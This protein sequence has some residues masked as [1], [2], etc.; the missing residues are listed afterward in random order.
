MSKAT[1]AA[2]I[3]ILILIVDQVIK[4]IVKTNMYL[5]ESIPVF[6]DWFKIR[7]IENPGMAFGIDIPGKFGKIALSLFRL[8]AIIGIIWYMRTL[9]QKKAKMLLVVCVSM[10]LAG[11]IGNLLD[12][13]FYGIIFDKGTIYDPQIGRWVGYSGLAQANFAGYA[14]PFK[15]CVVDWIYFPLIEGTYPRWIPVLGGRDFEFFRPIFNIADSAIS[16]GVVLILV[17]QK[18]L[19]KDL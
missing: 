16:I 17:F 5:G 3:V 10:I 11:A 15:G 18:R 19:F 1:K 13:I 12:S 7:Y 14:A 6:G 8:V 9:I 2:L 4:I